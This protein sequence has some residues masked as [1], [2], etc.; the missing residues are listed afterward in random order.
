MF[1]LLL[2]WDFKDKPREVFDQLRKYIA[3]ESW[4]RHGKQEGLRH[5]VWFSDEE[6]GKWG[7]FYLWESKEKMEEYIR[8]MSRVQALTGVAP[9]ILRYD[10]EA[11]QEGNHSGENLLSLGLAWADKETS[12]KN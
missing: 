4:Q 11:I 10:V 5:K 7:A 3:E 2:M 12:D 8:T 9:S 6:T 1:A